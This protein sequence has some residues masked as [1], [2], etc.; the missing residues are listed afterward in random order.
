MTYRDSR[1]KQQYLTLLNVTLLVTWWKR[2]KRVAFLKHIQED[3]YGAIGIIPT[4][5]HMHSQSWM[6][7]S[8][9]VK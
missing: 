6:L 3:D 1:S 9:P 5:T 7:S 4:H 2:G 8:G